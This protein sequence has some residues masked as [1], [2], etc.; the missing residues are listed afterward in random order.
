MMGM[1][2]LHPKLIPVGPPAAPQASQSS[3]LVTGAVSPSLTNSAVGGRL[4][5]LN[6]LFQLIVVCCCF[7]RWHKERP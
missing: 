3:P 7:L 4:T 5:F 2:E 6:L 1:E